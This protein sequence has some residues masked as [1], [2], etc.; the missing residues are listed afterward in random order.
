MKKLH[1]SS[2]DRVLTGVCG[3]LAEYFQVDS[4]LIRLIFIISIF[5]G[6]L[7]IFIYIVLFFLM[8]KDVQDVV[9]KNIGPTGKTMVCP[10]CKA[11][12]DSDF[13]Y[14]PHCKR[15]LRKK[16]NKCGTICEADWQN[17]PKCGDILN[18]EDT[19]PEKNDFNI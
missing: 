1:K 10:G 17:C 15:E 7:G 18:K 2:T 3:G 14:C 12:I 13:N 4:V 6:G 11:T 9:M 5:L 19:I 8:S 16:C